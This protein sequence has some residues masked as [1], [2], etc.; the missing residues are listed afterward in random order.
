MFRPRVLETVSSRV[1]LGFEV[2]QLGREIYVTTGGLTQSGG[3]ISQLW[4]N[5]LKKVARNFELKNKRWLILGL[6]TGTVAKLISQTYPP[7]QITGVELDPEMIRV[8]RKYFDLDKIPHL[9]IILGDALDYLKTSKT[10]FDIVLVDLYVAD[11]LPEFVYTP[12]FIKAVKRI[13]GLA[14]YNHLFYNSQNKFLAQRL[15]QHLA[16]VYSQTQLIRELSNLL[17]VCS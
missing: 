1:S 10:K 15:T 8:G 4:K 6:A 9:K 3:L 17:V 5:T 16:G 13:G 14:I 11:Q 2:R 12:T 7:T